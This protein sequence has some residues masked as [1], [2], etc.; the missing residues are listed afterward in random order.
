MIALSLI[1]AFVLG[2]FYFYDTFYP[3]DIDQRLERIEQ[4]LGEES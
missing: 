3:K 4:I 2:V 1:I